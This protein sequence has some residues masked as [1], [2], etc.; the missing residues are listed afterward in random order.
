MC[1]VP[2]RSLPQ[3]PLSAES[4]KTWTGKGSLLIRPPPSLCLLERLPRMCKGGVEPLFL[5]ISAAWEHGAHRLRLFSF[6]HTI[7]DGTDIVQPA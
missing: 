1:A 3:L 2:P 5:L 7:K 6:M 4:V